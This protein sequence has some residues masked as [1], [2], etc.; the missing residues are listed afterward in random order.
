MM[1]DPNADS[2]RQDWPQGFDV[3]H[4]Q[5]TINWSAIPNLYRFVFIKATDGITYQDPKFGAEILRGA[6]HFFETNDDGDAQADNFL[7]TVPVGELDL[8]PV[9]DIESNKT[10][11]DSATILKRLQAWLDA[12]QAAAGKPP[13]IYTDDSFWNGLCT[14]A[15]ADPITLRGAER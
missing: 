14:G 10:G 9:V 5:G 4:Y 3:S 11:V 8:P 1:T 7:K 2:S 15:A 6:Y 12:V 13:M